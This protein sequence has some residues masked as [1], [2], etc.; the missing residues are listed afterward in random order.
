MRG[1]AVGGTLGAVAGVL[2][3]VFFTLEK[4]ND[5]ATGKNK[6]KPRFNAA[7]TFGGLSGKDLWDAL[8]GTPPD[9]PQ[10]RTVTR[11]TARWTVKGAIPFTAKRRSACR[12][13]EAPTRRPVA[14]PN[15]VDGLPAS[16]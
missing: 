14:V 13:G 9:G 4:V 5:I 10:P 7:E 1:A 6:V 12:R 16:T 15:L 8:S 11:S 2:L 3:T